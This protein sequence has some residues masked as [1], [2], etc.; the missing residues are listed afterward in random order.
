MRITHKPLFASLAS[1]TLVASMALAVPAYAQDDND[2][3]TASAP[4]ISAHKSM[5]ASHVEEHIKSLHDKL[6]ITADQE[7]QWSAV[8]Q[9]MR[10]NEKA[11]HTLTEQRRASAGSLTAIDDLK[12]YQQIADEHA[13]GIKKLIPVFETLYDAMSDDQKKNADMVFGTY[14]G[15]GPHK[16]KHH[17]K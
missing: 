8:A 17:S 10:D 9:T 14:E 4:A 1:L 7:D 13:E 5:P 12:S 2:A 3:M 16:A 11:I 6:N 15:H